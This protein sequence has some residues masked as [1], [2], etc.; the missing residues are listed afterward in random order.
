MELQLGDVKNTYFKLPLWHVSSPGALGFFQ[1]S[2]AHQEA[3]SRRAGI[4]QSLR[5][6]QKGLR[7]TPP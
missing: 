7:L 3:S 4:A 2:V 1:L 5:L 6:E